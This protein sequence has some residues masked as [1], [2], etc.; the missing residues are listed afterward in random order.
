MSPHAKKIKRHFE[1]AKY[2]RYLILIL[3]IVISTLLSD[4]F[5]TSKNVTNLLN[6]NS[7]SGIV[8]IGELLVIITGGTD[9]SVGA[10]A[11]MCA[12]IVALFLKSGFHWLIA[13][14]LAMLVGLVAG[15]VNGVLVTR[16][17]LPSFVVTLA[18]MNIYQGVALLLSK[19]R[20]VFYKNDFFLKIGKTNVSIIPVVTILWLTLAFLTNIFLKKTVSG[21]YI[22]GIGG[23]RYAVRLSGVNVP[24]YESFAYTA[25]GVLS[26]IGGILM[27]SRLTLGSNSVGNGWELMAI[28]AVMVGGGSSVGGIGTAGGVVV[29]AIIMGLIGNIMNLTGITI[30]WQQIIRGLIIVIAVFTS[31]LRVQRRSD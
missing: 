26:A 13:S 22:H 17:R 10:I 11:S 4:K 25:S 19:G 20:E 30:Y 9:L 18:T 16:L 15:L 8:A 21:R 29:G 28:A 5:L 31:Q 3:F 12:V 1:W 27:A 6:Q 23:N 2:D 14:L 7:A 24:L